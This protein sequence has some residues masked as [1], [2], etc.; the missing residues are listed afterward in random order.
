M[1][2]R[3]EREGDA[4]KK[5]GKKEFSRGGGS[6]VP[7]PRR[8]KGI[9]N[10]RD[11]VSF[12]EF[13]ARV[14]R[15][16]SLRLE[17]SNLFSKSREGERSY[18]WSNESRLNGKFLSRSI[19]YRERRTFDISNLKTIEIYIYIRIKEKDEFVIINQRA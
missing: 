11:S 2:G 7:C 17:I 9:N 12:H 4:K 3:R 18:Q 8:R 5:K 15:Q 10:T 16:N 19:N 14:D 1:E 13:L 6:V